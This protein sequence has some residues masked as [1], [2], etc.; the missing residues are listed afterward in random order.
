LTQGA[1][2]KKTVQIVGCAGVT[3]KDCPIGAGWL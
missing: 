3:E 2:R 1:V